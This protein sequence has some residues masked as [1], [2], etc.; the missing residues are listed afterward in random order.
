M[1]CQFKNAR[2]KLKEL[3][4]GVRIVR[5]DSNSNFLVAASKFLLQFL[6]NSNPSRSFRSGAYHMPN[7]IQVTRRNWSEEELERAEI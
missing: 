1:L 3:E 5:G 7:L 6:Q 4:E 2:K